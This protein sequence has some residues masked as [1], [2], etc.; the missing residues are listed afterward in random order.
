MVLSA[1]E[2]TETGYKGIES[3]RVSNTL[4]SKL[5]DDLFMA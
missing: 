4:E 5:R 3:D 2:K 1:K